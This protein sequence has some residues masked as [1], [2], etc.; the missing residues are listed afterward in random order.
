MRLSLIILL[1]LAGCD[2]KSPTES[3]FRCDVT[4]TKYVNEAERQE[5][6]ED[7]LEFTDLAVNQTSEGNTEFL[8]TVNQCSPSDDDTVTPEVNIEAV[9]TETQVAT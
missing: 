8:V 1:V 9:G 5:M 2:Y 7:G 3:F 4:V 6:I